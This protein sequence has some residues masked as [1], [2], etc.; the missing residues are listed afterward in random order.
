[1]H[2]NFKANLVSAYLLT[3]PYSNRLGL[4]HIPI[5]MIAYDCSV[6]ME[7][8]RDALDCISACDFAKYDELTSFVW[9]IKMAGY[10]NIG[11]EPTKWGPMKPTDNNVISIRS[12]YLALRNNA[13][14]GEFFDYYA[15]YFHLR[16][17]DRRGPE[18]RSEI[19]DSPF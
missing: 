1:M 18:R 6:P 15:E 7:W 12:Q 3:S 8:V 11:R 14:L 13:F 17:E 19:D 9:V 5:P 16:P 2:D 10:Q 4:Y